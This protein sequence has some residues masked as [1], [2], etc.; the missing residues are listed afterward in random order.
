MRYKTNFIFTL[1][2][3]V[4]TL[5]S[6]QSKAKEL[7]IGLILFGPTGFTA[8]YFLDEQKAPFHGA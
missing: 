4:L 2:F 5:I 3:L 6:S 1:T 7:G 8:N